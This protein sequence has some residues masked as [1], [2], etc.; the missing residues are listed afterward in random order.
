M[1]GYTSC[2]DFCPTVL[3]EL[4]NLLNQMQD[5]QHKID[6]QVLF[7][8]IDPERDADR[9]SSYVEYFHPDIVGLIA[10]ESQGHQPLEKS[11]GM[12]YLVE[13]DHSDLGYSVAHGS[14][15]YL[16]DPQGKLHAIFKPNAVENFTSQQLYKD[17]SSLVIRYG[18]IQG[19]VI[20]EP[21]LKAEG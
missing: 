11:L 9:L 6:L 13:D 16:I 14:L 19:G 7:Y 1:Y 8:A 4:A 18:Q 2:P 17:L 5:T 20:S 3:R 21:S 10:S 15:L 12:Q